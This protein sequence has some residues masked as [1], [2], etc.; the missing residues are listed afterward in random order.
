MHARSCL[1]SQLSHLTG[2]FCTLYTLTCDTNNNNNRISI[3]PYGRNFK[4]HAIYSMV[5]LCPHNPNASANGIKPQT[6]RFLELK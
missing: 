1:S 4:F 6:P 3:V 5:V 2:H